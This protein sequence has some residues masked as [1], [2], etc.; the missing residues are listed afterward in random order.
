MN[1]NNFI[2]HLNILKTLVA[3]YVSFILKIPKFLAPLIYM[4]KEFQM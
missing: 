4:G 3:I 1:K 2:H